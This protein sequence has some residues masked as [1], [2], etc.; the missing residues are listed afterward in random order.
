MRKTVGLFALTAGI[1]AA[2]CA[3]LPHTAKS[4]GMSGPVTL[5]L[6]N[7]PYAEGRSTQAL[8]STAKQVVI[9]VFK[10]D[11]TYGPTAGSGGMGGTSAAGLELA[12][13]PIAGTVLVSSASI[14]STATKVTLPGIPSG[15]HVIKMYVF[16]TKNAQHNSVTGDLYGGSDQNLIAESE[17]YVNPIVGVPL[18]AS[19]PMWS[20]YAINGNLHTVDNTDATSSASFSGITVGTTGLYLRMADWNPFTR[21]ATQTATNDFKIR[22]SITVN[23]AYAWTVA[24][25]SAYWKL[26]HVASPFGFSTTKAITW[27]F[28]E[29]RKA[30]Y[31]D[32]NPYDADGEQAGIRKYV[33]ATE[34]AS[35]SLSIWL[36]NTLCT[37]GYQVHVTDANEGMSLG[38]NGSI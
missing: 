10:A 37:T 32:I 22:V 9:K 24:S 7:I 2:G 12:T 1:L 34:H 25:D 18:N 23:T 36:P 33:D 27:A 11:A 6:T 38:G 3:I 17:A 31:A 16:S 35:G 8:K 15:G 14:T 5:N 28:S 20:T 13:D 26:G 30:V 29:D 19:L 4:T 21:L